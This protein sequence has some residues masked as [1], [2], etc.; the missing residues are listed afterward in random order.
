MEAGSIGVNFF[1]ATGG[2]QLLAGLEMDQYYSGSGPA[3]P[4]LALHSGGATRTTQSS[5]LH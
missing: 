5:V 3:R 4:P 1:T 2:Q